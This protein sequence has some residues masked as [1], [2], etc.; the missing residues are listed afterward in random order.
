MKDMKQ[1]TIFFTPQ[2]GLGPIKDCI[3]VL[4]YHRLNDLTLFV[5]SLV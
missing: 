5:N 2:K 1:P 4:C 3:M